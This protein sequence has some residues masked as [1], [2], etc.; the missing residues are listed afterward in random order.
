MEKLKE[1]KLNPKLNVNPL[2]A[3]FVAPK[4]SPHPQTNFHF[5]VYLSVWPYIISI[6]FVYVYPLQKDEIQLDIYL[7]RHV[8]RFVFI[9]IENR[10]LTKPSAG[11]QTYLSGYGYVQMHTYVS[12]I[13]S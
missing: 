13:L 7:S 1:R 2:K 11:R 12:T 10:L 8:I 9:F 3:P 4:L 6:L 5:S